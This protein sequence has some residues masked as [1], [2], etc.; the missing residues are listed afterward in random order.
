L[1]KAK[2]DGVSL[3]IAHPVGD[4]MARVRRREGLESVRWRY[5]V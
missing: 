3:G 1:P 4:V 5:A 2:F